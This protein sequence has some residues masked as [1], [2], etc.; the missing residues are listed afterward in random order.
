MYFTVLFLKDDSDFKS[1][2]YEQNI[3][4]VPELNTNEDFF[5]CITGLWVCQ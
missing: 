4:P 5:T 2:Q 1:S 3:L